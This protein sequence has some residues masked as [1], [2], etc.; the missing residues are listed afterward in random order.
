MSGGGG[1]Y[2]EERYKNIYIFKCAYICIKQH[3]KEPD[4]KTDHLIR[5]EEEEL[6]EQEQSRKVKL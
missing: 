3:W 5:R 1:Q 2:R 6:R 4:L